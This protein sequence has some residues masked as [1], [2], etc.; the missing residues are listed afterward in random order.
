MSGE[1][2]FFVI[3]ILVAFSYL[4][5]LRLVKDKT[6]TL[7]RHRKIWNWMLLLSFAVSGLGGMLLS[8]AID[9]GIRLGFYSLILWLHVEAGIA[10]AVVSV[11]HILRHKPYF[12]QGRK[13]E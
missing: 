10:M 8:F 9:S 1:Y 3:L 11:F 2:N 4:F 5:S 7:L 13:K 12:L 6:I